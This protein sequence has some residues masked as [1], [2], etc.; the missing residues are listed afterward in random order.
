MQYTGMWIWAPIHN[1]VNHNKPIIAYA[2]LRVQL[3]TLCPAIYSDWIMTSVSV[4]KWWR[5]WFELVRLFVCLFVHIRRLLRLTGSLCV[6]FTF[7]QIKASGSL[8]HNNSKEKRWEE[9]R[10]PSHR[11]HRKLL[12]LIDT[13][14][15]WEV[16]YEMYIIE[17]EILTS[18]FRLK[19]VCKLTNY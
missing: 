18:I 2:S 15:E 13:P 8:R 10:T 14:I 1:K 4:C 7:H 19:W 12:N 6:K 5:N 9:M 11:N 16:H 17:R 3:N